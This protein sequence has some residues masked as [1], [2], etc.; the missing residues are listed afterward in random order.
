MEKGQTALG[1]TS[2]LPVVLMKHWALIQG[3]DSISLGKCPGIYIFHEALER[4][5]RT[6]CFRWSILS[7]V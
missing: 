7:K 4:G 2:P 1:Y 5:F 6:V 3:T